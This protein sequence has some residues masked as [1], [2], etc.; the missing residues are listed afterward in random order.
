MRQN[1]DDHTA[2]PSVVRVQLG[3]LTLP[4]GPTGPGGAEAYTQVLTNPDAL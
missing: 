2:I 3:L 1:G 4:T